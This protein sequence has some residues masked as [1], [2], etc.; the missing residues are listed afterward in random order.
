MENKEVNLDEKEELRIRMAVIREKYRRTESECDRFIRKE[1][2]W[3]TP[4]FDQDGMLDS[5]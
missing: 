3:L 1:V 4:P 5:I 2:G